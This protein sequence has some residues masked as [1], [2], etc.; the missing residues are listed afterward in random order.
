MRDFTF[1]PP[2]AEQSKSSRLGSLAQ[3]QRLKKL[4][5]ARGILIF[6]GLL[7]LAVTIWQ[8]STMEAQLS[9]AIDDQVQQEALRRGPLVQVDQ[10]KVEEFKRSAEFHAA[11]R[12]AKLVAWG[13][14][15]LGGLFVLFGIILHS[16]PV[17]ITVISLV[18]YVGV[19]A[20]FLVM[21]PASFFKGTVA[22]YIKFIVIAGLF[23]GVKAAVAYQGEQNR[24]AESAETI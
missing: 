4:N 23:Q 19:S 13:L 18:L 1:D 22:L 21:D 7:T 5:E 6:V 20:V 9:R 24:P 16:D 8:L 15:F 11:V 14:I 17:P 3:T 2:A 10:A 12:T